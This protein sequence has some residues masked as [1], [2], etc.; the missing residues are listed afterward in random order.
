L[1]TDQ[2]KNLKNLNKNKKLLKM[3]INKFF[4]ELSIQDY[5][6]L[7]YLYLVILGIINIVIYYSSF[8]INIFDYISITD[9]LLAPVNMLFLSYEFTAMVIIAVGI[10]S[11]LSKFLAIGVNYI[12]EKWAIKFNYPIRSVAFSPVLVFIILFSYVFLVLSVDMAESVKQRVDNKAFKPNTILTL[13]DNA[14]KN[15]KVIA[16]TSMYIFYVELGENIVNIMP[17][18]GNVKSIKKI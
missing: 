3:N 7:G 17:I 11:Y 9:I 6:T 18:S 14:Q 5:I 13:S 12:L 4:K 10:L 16:T 2:V 8:E 1:K 15:V